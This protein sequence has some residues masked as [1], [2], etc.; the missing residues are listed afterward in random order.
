M[1]FI[2]LIRFLR[3]H[4]SLPYYHEEQKGLSEGRPWHRESI[5]HSVVKCVYINT[6]ATVFISFSLPLLD[7]DVLT[8]ESDQLVRCSAYPWFWQE[9]YISCF[10]TKR[11]RQKQFCSKKIISSTHTHNVWW[12]VEVT[13]EF[14]KNLFLDQQANSAGKSICSQVWRSQDPTWWKEGSQLGNCPLTA[15]CAHIHTYTWA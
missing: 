2:V 10:W 14:K 11:L 12:I 7:T 1:T 6:R 3:S 8:C 15:R 9:R 5:K 13:Q 4:W